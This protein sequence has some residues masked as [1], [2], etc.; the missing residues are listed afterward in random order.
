MPVVVYYSHY[1]R[2]KAAA[3]PDDLSHA[4]QLVDHLIA[5]AN[6]S[7]MAL[8]GHPD[9][10]RMTRLA[11]MVGA[12]HDFGKY[13]PYFQEY[14]R[15]GRFASPQ[16]LRQKQHAFISAL[17]GAYQVFQGEENDSASSVRD[18]MLV[19]LAIKRHHSSLY[20]LDEDIGT[21]KAVRG[22]LDAVPD[23]LN[24]QLEIV[25]SQI[26]AMGPAVDA[27]GTEL[28]SVFAHGLSYG[29]AGDPHV[30]S[31]FERGWHETFSRLADAYFRRNNASERLWH[32]D[33]TLYVDLLSLFSALIDADK[34][35]AAQVES[36]DRPEF[37]ADLVHRKLDADSVR[38]E[39]GLMDGIRSGLL[40][41]VLQTAQ[42]V[43]LGAS[44]FTLTAPT[45]AGK[46]YAGFTA[47]SV[48]RERLAQLRGRSPRVV[49]ALPFTAIVDQV[50]ANVHELLS[51]V[52]GFAD[53]EERFVVC[54]HHLVDVK[55]AKPGG[56]S[57]RRESFRAGTAT[58][59]ERAMDEALLFVEG[60]DSELIVT[61]FVQLLET[62]VGYQNRS[63]K[64]FHRIR[65]AIVIL[66]EVQAIRAE[67]WPL[68][69]N[70]F[71]LMT[72]QMGCKIILMTATQPE[73]LQGESGVVELAGL[74]DQVSAMFA[75]LDRVDLHVDLTPVCEQDIVDDFI[76]NF[77]SAKRYLVV[78]NTIG[79]SLAI[80]QLLQEALGERDLVYLS[81]NIVPRERRGR[82]LHLK[83]QPAETA[84][85]VVS[86][87]VVE[88]G[89]DLDFDVVIRD[90][91][92]LDSIVQIAGRCNRHGLRSRGAVHIVNLRKGTQESVDGRGKMGEY[93]RLVYGAVHRDVTVETLRGALGG[94]LTGTISERAFPDL[95]RAFYTRLEP[96][97]GEGHSNVI[98]SAMGRL[99]FSSSS[100][101]QNRVGSFHLIEDRPSYVD[102]YVDW[103]GESEETWDTYRESVLCEDDLTRRRRNFLL[104][105]ARFLGNVISLPLKKTIEL[106]AQQIGERHQGVWRLACRNDANLYRLD[107]GIVRSLGDV[108]MAY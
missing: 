37:P 95:V 32:P 19:Y 34:R 93:C 73:L 15:K 82:I 53:N 59:E 44:L 54:H 75:A 43:D 96:R 84:Y 87:Q 94:Q 77:D 46:T 102:V 40:N 10:A 7:A 62:V 22:N 39:P 51:T 63:L 99:D 90:L 31:F 5:V 4:Q 74:P 50:L 106:G 8:T 49:Y 71:R 12:T 104:V 21:H 98:W 79:T 38:G 107:T 70:V 18:A 57:E 52:D 72:E 103:D 24:G 108:F 55:P 42:E 9:A 29:A 14:L 105:R 85:V 61:T 100:G 35:S 48:L 3:A 92:P 17:F 23:P 68:L 86:T 91:G 88:A 78:M 89:V 97:I 67:W 80:F 81:T 2:E 20:N 101:N 36:K 41:S 60:W 26:A 45:G 13:T 30:E 16:A 58:D 28:R 56:G 47:A 27:I 25:H 6:A 76:K 64:K 11:Y 66:D 1:D 65:D 69:R 83:N 33:Q